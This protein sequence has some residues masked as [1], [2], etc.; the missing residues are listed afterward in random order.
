MSINKGTIL[1][2]GLLFLPGG[3]LLQAQGSGAALLLPL[4]PRLLTGSCQ[5]AARPGVLQVVTVAGL[6]DTHTSSPPSRFSASTAA[7]RSLETLLLAKQKFS[8]PLEKQIKPSCDAAS[9]PCLVFSCQEPD[10]RLRPLKHLQ[11]LCRGIPNQ[12]Q[13]D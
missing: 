8:L 10:C 11:F 3:S 2:L 5:G 13:W 9:S 6:K 12:P 4:H 1:P 7:L